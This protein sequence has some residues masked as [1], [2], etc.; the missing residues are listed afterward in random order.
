MK[1]ERR[2][3][4][5]TNTLAKGIEKLP[6]VGREH[7]T[8]ILLAVALVILSAVAVRYWLSNR[9]ARIERITGD[10]ADS[11]HMLS[12]LRASAALNLNPSLSMQQIRE[13]QSQRRSEIEKKI[14]DV[15]TN[16]S[17]AAQIADAKLVRGDLYWELGSQ[18]DFQDLPSASA[19]TRP[20]A[21]QPQ[22]SPQRQSEMLDLAAREYNSVLESAAAGKLSAQTVA[23]AR[24]G[25]AAI[26]ENKGD[27][28]TART[29]YDTI[30]KDPDTGEALRGQARFRHD[31]LT[32][33]AMPA[34]V[35]HPTKPPAA[36]PAPPALPAAPAGPAVPLGPAFTPSLSIP[37][38]TQPSTAPAAL[39]VPP[40]APISSPTTLPAGDTSSPVT[41]PPAT[42]QP[43]A[44]TLPSP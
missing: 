17:D 32:Q 8:R 24:F 13:F 3:D 43:S 39:L 42:T 6:S 30:A 20:A 25:L 21:T 14:E 19:A 28:P 18:P 15:L 37:A 11:E 2:H 31:A 33:L 16:S 10:I 12:E 5:E 40:A 35:G 41:A 23:R 44:T 9:A 22:A 38:D 36:I 34:F 4:L 27:W 26:A 1:S 29:L 7:G